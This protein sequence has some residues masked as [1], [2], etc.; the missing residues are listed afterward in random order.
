MTK[1]TDVSDRIWQNYGCNIHVST[2]DIRT[3]NGCRELLTQAGHLGVI[4][5]I[6]NLAVRLRDALIGNQTANTFAECMAPK[7]DATRHLDAAAR[8]LCLR[9]SYFVCFSSVSGGRGNAGQS[10]YGMAN[11]AMERIVERR[12]AD[13]LAGKAIQWG[14]VGEVGLVARMIDAQIGRDATA[15]DVTEIAGT[16]QQRIGSCL[17][18]LDVLLTSP[19]AV[20]ASMVVAKKRSASD[21]RANVASATVLESVLH[22]MCIRNMNS[23]SMNTSLSELGMDS[24]MTVEIKQTLER[25]FDITLS[26]PELRALT[27][28]RLQE[29]SAQRSTGAAALGV[30][31]K[32]PL[33]LRRTTIFDIGGLL[34]DEV[35][36]TLSK[37]GEE[38]MYALKGDATDENDR[39]WIVMPGVEGDNRPVWRTIADSTK[40]STFIL[41]YDEAAKEQSVLVLAQMYAKVSHIATSIMPYRNLTKCALFT[42]KKDI[43]NRFPKRQHFAFIAYSFGTI[44][45]I[46]V[47][48]LLEAEGQRG[49]IVCI[50]GAPTFLRQLVYSFI[51][52]RTDEAF[53]I[54]HLENRIAIEL[55]AAYVPVDSTRS[56]AAQAISEANLDKL[57][58]WLQKIDAVVEYTKS[59]RGRTFDDRF[60]RAFATGLYRRALSALEYTTLERS[61][62][63]GAAVTLVRAVDGTFDDI[64]EHYDLA[65][66]TA[67]KVD[68]KRVAGN[69]QTILQ[70][71]CLANIINGVEVF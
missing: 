59:V 13:G 15:A 4:D 50:D 42:S 41:R 44:I 27:F 57:D 20:V 28:L 34:R 24:L 3:A 37:T 6:F 35:D 38:R 25:E 63:I 8:Q 7:A 31:M 64:D 12:V 32:Q 68:V 14:A 5:G 10:N 19:E 71:G 43:K 22:I 66:Y 29:L 45:A 47:A 39:I 69:H 58:G 9:L 1:P 54:A 23:I 61:A 49:H 26:T 65:R 18:E 70:S 56:L 55:I 52:R 62:R 36:A 51:G 21:E 2:A 11:A 67:G 16:L 60:L 33:P 46:E 30:K 17:A 40:G 53:S 48:R